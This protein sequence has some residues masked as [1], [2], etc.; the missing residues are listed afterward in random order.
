[1][2][3]YSI[4]KQRNFWIVAPLDLRDVA[5][6]LE[7]AFGLADPDFGAEDDEEWVEGFA[8]N[9]V[10]FYVCRQGGVTAP[11]R[12][13]I[14]PYLPDPTEFGHR[15]ASCLGKSVSYGDVTYLGDEKFSYSE[16]CRYEPAL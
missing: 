13:I 4:S 1:M 12:F 11:L 8:R 5:S 2:W 9:G 15:L 10:A 16:I 7:A 14:N 3:A 6:R